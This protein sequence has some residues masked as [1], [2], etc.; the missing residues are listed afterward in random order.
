MV[1]NIAN[2]SSNCLE[3]TTSASLQ[4]DVQGLNYIPR[5]QG[6]KTTNTSDEEVEIP[7]ESST[8]KPMKKP[9]VRSVPSPGAKVSFFFGSIILV[10]CSFIFLFLGFKLCSCGKQCRLVLFFDGRS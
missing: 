5:S 2:A 8:N 3:D 7:F 10:A 4:N 1:E 6:D 9:Y